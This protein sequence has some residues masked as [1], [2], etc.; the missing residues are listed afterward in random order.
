M[1]VV[2]E[3]VVLVRNKRSCSRR[4]ILHSIKQERKKAE[5]GLEHTDVFRQ[6]L[7]AKNVCILR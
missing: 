6:K 5:F 7:I 3:I 2:S 4:I 1:V